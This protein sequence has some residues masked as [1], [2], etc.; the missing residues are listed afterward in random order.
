MTEL[1]EDSK[2]VYV[3]CSA[4]FVPLELIHGR[5]FLVSSEAFPSCLETSHRL[6]GSTK[7]TKG[8]SE[9][10]K[11]W[12]F[13]F[14]A[15]TWGLQH[16]AQRF[17]DPSFSFFPFLSFCFFFCL[18]FPL[19]PSLCPSFPPPFFLSFLKLHALRSF[20]LESYN[21]LDQQHQHGLGDCEKCRLSGSIPDLLN[22]NPRF[23]KFPRWF[24]THSEA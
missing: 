1:A 16:S 17:A 4:C 18:S 3:S 12:K 19:C 20:S 5:I 7:M 23:Y 6:R 22:P 9:S 15:S 10:Q 8:R 24:T 11:L 2:E 13:H 14:W 21:S